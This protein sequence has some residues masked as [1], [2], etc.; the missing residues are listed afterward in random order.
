MQI[1]RPSA[2][3]AG[4]RLPLWLLL[5]VILAG[6]AGPTLDDYG[7]RHPQLVPDRFFDGELSAQG[8]VKDW[9]G[10]VIRTFDADIDASW[11]ARGVGTLDEVF[12]F[13]DGEVQT[14]TWT[15]TP[16]DAGYHAD[17]GDVVEPGTMRWQGNAIHMNYV[18]RVSY[19]DGTID[20]RMDDWMYLVTPDTLINQTTMSKWGVDVGEVVLVITKNDND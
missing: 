12:R 1:P 15:L 11:D 19:G 18:L 4:L 6:C 17:A 13:D 5:T 9:S 10:K 2:T 14:R 20:V 8:V 16:S 7:D 3:Q